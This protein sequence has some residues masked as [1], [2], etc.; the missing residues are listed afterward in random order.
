MQPAVFHSTVRDLWGGPQG[1]CKALVFQ[2]TTRSV[3][4]AD[5]YETFT[6][7]KLANLIEFVSGLLFSVLLFESLRLRNEHQKH[8]QQPSGGLR[9]LVSLA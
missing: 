4:L 9:R 7:L 2:C 1:I 6:Q 3:Q 5:L 8:S